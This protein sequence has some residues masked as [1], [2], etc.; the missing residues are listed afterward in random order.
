MSLPATTKIFRVPGRLAI[1]PTALSAAFPHGGTA[2]GASS[3]IRIV[4]G[5]EEARVTA[6]E[7]SGQ[8]VEAILGK[9]DFFMSCLLRQWDN[10]AL[11]T[12]YGQD[13][14]T[15]S[16]GDKLISWPGTNRGGYQLSNR[17]V[18]LVFT[19][20]RQTE[21]PSLLIYKAI[22]LYAEFEALRLTI[23]SELT[24]PAVFLGIRDASSR[25][26]AMG[27]LSDLTL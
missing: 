26:A 25:V 19:A 13:A 24:M 2:I 23:V 17:A 5:L 22:P 15:G 6:E 4:T 16:S 8:A 20:N 7:F 9:R 18:K 21:H 27:L 12:L 1:T 3:R 14:T 10:D 11:S